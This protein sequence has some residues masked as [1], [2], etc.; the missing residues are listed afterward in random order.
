MAAA[1]SS[2]SAAAA[3]ATASTKSDPYAQHLPAE[4]IKQLQR[5]L[6]KQTVTLPNGEVDDGLWSA[7]SVNLCEDLTKWRFVKV[8][9]RRPHI[10]I[11]TMRTVLEKGPPAVYGTSYKVTIFKI[12]PL[13]MNQVFRPKANGDTIFS[14]EF[15][16]ASTASPFD[17]FAQAITDYLEFEDKFTHLSWLID[18]ANAAIVQDP[19]RKMADKGPAPKI[20]TFSAVGH[21]PGSQ[22]QLLAAEMLPLFKAMGGSEY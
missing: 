1:I 18:L 2:S 5:T 16:F 21:A 8:L 9:H 14:R 11:N 3:S 10:E 6:L 19:P 20:K 13:T 12:I 4:V 7:P 17:G 15:S 22:G